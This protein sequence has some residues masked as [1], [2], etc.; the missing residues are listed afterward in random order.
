ME[1]V[2]GVVGQFDLKSIHHQNTNSSLHD[3][4]LPKGPRL[5]SEPLDAD[6]PSG[7]LSAKATHYDGGS[8]WSCCASVNILYPIEECTDSDAPG[9]SVR[10]LINPITVRAVSRSWEIFTGYSN[11]RMR[12]NSFLFIRFGIIAGLKRPFWEYIFIRPI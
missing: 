7:S 12:Y 5:A 4:R 1:G 8:Y 3:E 9:D 10:A 2:E 6:T 11:Y